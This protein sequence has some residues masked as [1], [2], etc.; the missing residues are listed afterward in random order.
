[1]RAHANTARSVLDRVLGRGTKQPGSL[2][3]RRNRGAIWRGNIPKKYTR[4]V[5]L[6]PGRRILELGSA[7]GVLA[8]LLAQTKHRVIA[9]EQNRERHE[10]A[11]RL[12]SQ[13][14]EN[15]LDVVRCEM[16]QGDI[17]ERLELLESVD[18]LIAVRSIYYLRDTI[19]PVFAAVSRHV[20]NVVLCGNKNRARHYH[21][22]NGKPD[23][24]LGPFN[25]FAT[26]EGMTSLLS[27][28]GYRIAQTVAEGDPIVVGVKSAAD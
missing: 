27:D 18:T 6:V 24:P 23:D 8:L 2:E 20:E 4:L 5:D 11:L 25:Y 13:W 9:L 7:E 10:E 21:E 16:V 17:R 22:T 26:L 14:Q 15:G 12:Q 3:Y 19:R 28:C 1:M